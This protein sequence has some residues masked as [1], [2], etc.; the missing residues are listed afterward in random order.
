MSVM[1]CTHGRQ[2]SICGECYPSIAPGNLAA[3]ELTA[4]SS[5]VRSSARNP[6]SPGMRVDCLTRYT[7]GLCGNV[8]TVDRGLLEQGAQIRQCKSCGGKGGQAWGGPPDEL[9]AE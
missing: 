2:Q 7:C 1:R 5:A 4:H 3:E 9:K 6:F 8:E